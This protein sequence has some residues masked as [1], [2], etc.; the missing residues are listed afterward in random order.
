MLKKLKD[1]LVDFDCPCFINFI[2]VY[3]AP[4]EKHTQ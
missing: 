2:D 3:P 1:N 4:I